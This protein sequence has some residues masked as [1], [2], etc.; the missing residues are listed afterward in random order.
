M[1]ELNIGTPA[2]EF[3][4]TDQNGE[5]V[6]LADFKGKQPVVLIFYP[7]DE[8]PGCTKQLCAARDDTSLYQQA[9]VAVFGV[10]PGSAASHEK[11]IKKHNLTTPLLVDKGLE[12]AANYQATIGFGPLKIVN[13][14][15]VG[16]DR[17][18]KIAFYRRG[19]PATTEILAAL[20]AKPEQ[21]KH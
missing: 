2:P 8:T 6:R 18:G 19:I 12:V 16:I 5:T 10:N 3:A 13:R 1:A 4:L 7:A 11:F 20:A 15:V 9:G 17:D 21:V 14:T